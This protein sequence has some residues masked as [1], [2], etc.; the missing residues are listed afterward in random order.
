MPGIENETF[1]SVAVELWEADKFGNRRGEE[2]ADGICLSYSTVLSE[3]RCSR[4]LGFS[5]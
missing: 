5:S 4:S 1:S 2:Q 3:Q